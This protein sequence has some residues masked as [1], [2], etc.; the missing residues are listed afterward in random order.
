[1]KLI[2]EAPYRRHLP[3]AKD[4]FEPVRLKTVCNGVS[5]EEKHPFEIEIFT[6]NREFPGTDFAW[7]RVK[8]E[9]LKSE[10][11]QSSSTEFYNRTGKS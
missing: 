11:V 6:L 9:F 2:P 8:M 1:M 10:C 5:T 3:F 7:R 4:G